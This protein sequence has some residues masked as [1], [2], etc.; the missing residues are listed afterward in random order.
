M[1]MTLLFFSIFIGLSMQAQNRLI[2]K[3]AT[4]QFFSKM[5]L[6]NIEAINPNG[7]SVIDKTTGQLEFSVLMKGFKFE[8]A[9]MQEHFNENYVESD[10][11]PKATFKGKFDNFQSINFAKDGL[12]T[13]T[14]TGN[15]QLHGITKPIS[16]KVSLVVK[17][18]LIIGESNFEIK[19][20]DY[21]IKIPSLVKDKISKTVLITIKAP[22]Q[23]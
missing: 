10:Q 7:I 14:V 19:L 22:Y 17:N 5:P 11:F 4:I 13:T 18:Q 21:R 23:N 20:E 8:K 1:K 3:S 2:S 16:T 6:E 12:Y 15:I 9:L